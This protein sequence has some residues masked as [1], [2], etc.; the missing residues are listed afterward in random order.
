M[1][2]KN[3]NVR[4]SYF[5]L[6]NCLQNINCIE[7]LNHASGYSK[8]VINYIEDVLFDV[9]KL[10]WKALLDR[11]TSIRGNGGNKLRTYRIVKS[12]FCTENYLKTNIPFNYRS[13]FTKFRCGVA[14][15][16][17]ETGRYENLAL[18]NRCCFYCQNVVEDEKHVLYHCPLYNE[19][20]TE[21][22][23]VINS[24]QSVSY[25]NLSDDEKLL[26]TFKNDNNAYVAA[27]TCFKIL[28]E[29]KQFLYSRT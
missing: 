1:W 14:P 13:A 20:R 22:I 16:R 7:L 27:K 26:A 9:E 21:L 29:R 25:E 28:Y 15:L 19:C 5:R 23:S 18:E 10:K 4:N 12:D 17:V 2:S 11:N 3:A 6:K 24:M 8:P